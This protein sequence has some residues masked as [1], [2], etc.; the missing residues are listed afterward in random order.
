MNR[1][2]NFYSRASLRKFQEL[3]ARIHHTYVGIRWISQ[4]LKNLEEGGYINRRCRYVHFADGHILQRPSLF[5]FTVQG[6]KFFTQHRVK[7][8]KEL[9]QQVINH[10]RSK[11]KIPRQKQHH[12]I[13]E[14]RK[15]YPG[16]MAR[17]KR[18][19]EI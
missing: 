10:L 5:S 14:Y 17:I 15:L 8:A 6:A 19:R 13:K 11:L 4:C 2:T 3:L 9:L 7:G 1:K 18:T 16:E 12:D